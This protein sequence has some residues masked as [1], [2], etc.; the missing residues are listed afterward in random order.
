MLA[1]LN[2]KTNVNSSKTG[3]LKSKMNFNKSLPP[4]TA[5]HSLKPIRLVPTEKSLPQCVD[6]F[7]LV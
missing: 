4:N 1:N 6:G 5:V 3:I 2:T 7:A